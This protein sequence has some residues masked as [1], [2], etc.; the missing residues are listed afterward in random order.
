MSEFPV[1]LDD[2]ISYVRGLHRAGGPLDHLADAVMVAA[3]VNEQSDAL[4]GY[5]VDQARASGASWSEIGGSMGVSKQAAQKRFVARDDQILPEGNKRFTRFTP[6][7]RSCLGAAGQ[8]AQEAGSAEV[9]L[10][11]LVAGLLDEPEGVAARAVRRLGVTER[12]VYET[13]GT[14]GPTQAYDS[15]AGALRQLVFG[16]D[17]R[18]A[19]RGALRAALRLGHNYIGTEHLLLG[20]LSHRGDAM[21]RLAALGLTPAIVDRAIAVELAELQLELQ[22]R[23]G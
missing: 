1:P 5:F 18:T 14:A 7:A 16:G 23:D 8:I 21:D 22:R 11:H 17:T 19:L 15:D 6:R 12:Q 9:G 13:L 3:R 10:D 20:A 2:L 4:I